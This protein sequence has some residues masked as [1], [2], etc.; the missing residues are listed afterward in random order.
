[1]S[2]LLPTSVR[3]TRTVRF[4]INNDD[5]HDNKPAEA[6]D[7]EPGSAGSTHNTYAAWP[8]MTG[9]GRYYE[10]DVT[11]AGTPDPETGYCINITEIDHAVRTVAIPVIQH[12]VVHEPA[13]TNP[14]DLLPRLIDAL[15]QCIES[16]GSDRVRV[17]AIR[18]RLTPFYS[19]EL[20]RHSM[21]TAV[22]RDTFS[23]AAS[24]RLHC[25]TLSDEENRQVFGKCN[26]PNGHGHNYKLEVAVEVPIAA[27]QT[28][29]SRRSA[30]DLHR[31]ER[32]I[33]ETII[34]RFDHKH[35]NSDC[36]EFAEVNPSVENIARIT[37]D[38]LKP[39]LADAS[40]PLRNVTIWETEKTACVYPG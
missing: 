15:A 31:L 19:V 18:W 12:A 36:E 5:A 9:L 14:I 30:P 8:A 33:D 23:F 28:S 27:S 2:T 6:G 13:K 29:E 20:E 25:P 22:I 40:L 34:T 10:L 1:M 4:C 39:A 24:H 16:D 32:I 11:V 21:S 35:L 7:V 3:L 26:N 17:T 38:L 37:Y